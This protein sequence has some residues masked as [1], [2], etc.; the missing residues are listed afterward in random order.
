M[1][2]EQQFSDLQVLKEEKVQLT[3]TARDLA[4]RFEDVCEQN[5][6]IIARLVD[7]WLV[8]D[9]LVDDWSVDDWSVAVLCSI[10]R[11]NNKNLS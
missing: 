11:Q 7:D 2:K 3:D 10:K 9:W 8:D 5:D 1:L 6:E 4:E